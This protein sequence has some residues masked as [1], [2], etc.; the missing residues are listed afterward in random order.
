MPA[1]RLDAGRLSVQG[2]DQLDLRGE[3]GG[4]GDVRIFAGSVR[5][6]RNEGEAELFGDLCETLDKKEGT[7]AFLE[8]RPPKFSD[9]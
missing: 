5:P 7:A 8:K 6:R 2:A 1:P 9:R 4:I 3:D